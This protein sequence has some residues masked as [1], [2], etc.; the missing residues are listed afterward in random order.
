MHHGPERDDDVRCLRR[1]DV[2]VRSCPYVQWFIDVVQQ[3]RGLTQVGFQLALRHFGL[4]LAP[5]F[6]FGKL[7]PRLGS[8]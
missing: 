8:L 2:V 5:D 6:A 1:I 4:A 3:R 7:V